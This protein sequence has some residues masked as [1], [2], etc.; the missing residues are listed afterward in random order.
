MTSLPEKHRRAAASASPYRS[1]TGQ[2]I[3]VRYDAKTNM[4]MI[5]ED[6]WFAQSLRSTALPSP[7]MVRQRLERRRLT[8]R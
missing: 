8:S 6:G 4:L 3:L 5:A 1:T 7:S 2:A